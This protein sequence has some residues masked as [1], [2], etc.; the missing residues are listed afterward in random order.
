[1]M[2]RLLPI[3]W[4]VVVERFPKVADKML[5]NVGKY[6]LRD[7]AGQRT[8]FSKLSMGYDNPVRPRRAKPACQ[9]VSF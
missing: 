3:A 2:H 4:Q 9:P 7:G 8:G 1:M 5:A 6:A